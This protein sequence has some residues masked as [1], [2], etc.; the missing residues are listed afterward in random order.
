LPGARYKDKKP[1][2]EINDDFKMGILFSLY[3]E[4]KKKRF[5]REVLKNRFF[6]SYF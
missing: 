6:G 3:L 4:P 5:F 2:F 1:N